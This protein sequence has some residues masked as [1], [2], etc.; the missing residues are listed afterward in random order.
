MKRYWIVILLWLSVVIAGCGHKKEV[1]VPPMTNTGAISTSNENTPIISWWMLTGSTWIITIQA[2]SNLISKKNNVYS[3]W[4][5]L[6]SV[7]I[8]SQPMYREY[9]WN[10]HIEK[11]ENLWLRNTDI[12]WSG[13]ITINRQAKING[14]NNKC[15]LY[16]NNNSP[17]EWT[18]SENLQ[19]QNWIN[20]KTVLSQL[21]FTF[22]W[23]TNKN[24]YWISCFSLWN[25]N[26]EIHVNN[27]AKE[28]I[29]S[30]LNSI[31]LT[32]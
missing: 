3:F 5:E 32:K 14:V 15:E 16:K 23:E 25:Y 28:E 6:F 18:Y 9:L 30:I 11:M 13:E 31:L 2:N 17:I 29:V 10:E 7:T 21:S 24:W 27:F 1:I 26:Y 22:D 20:I 4:N 19:A 8:D 12:S